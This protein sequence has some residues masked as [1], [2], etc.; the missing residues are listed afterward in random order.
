MRGDFGPWMYRQKHSKIYTSITHGSINHV[1]L[2]SIEK[3]NSTALMGPNEMRKI[4]SGLFVR[5]I[6]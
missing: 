4:I 5:E 3:L 1:S 2:T 6:S